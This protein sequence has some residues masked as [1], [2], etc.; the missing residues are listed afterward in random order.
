MYDGKLFIVL[1]FNCCWKYM[2]NKRLK[3][4]E[5]ICINIYICIV[6][7]MV[8]IVIYFNKRILFLLFILSMNIS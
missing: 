7:I 4:C 6:S 2:L 5:M 8:L 3:G 1:R